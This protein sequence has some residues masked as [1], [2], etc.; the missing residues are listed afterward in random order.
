MDWRNRRA[1]SALFARHPKI[2][3]SKD[4]SVCADFIFK[5]RKRRLRSRGR[6]RRLCGLASSEEFFL[7]AYNRLG[8]AI[9]RPFGV[10]RIPLAV[11]FFPPAVLR[12]ENSR[13][14]SEK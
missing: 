1:G 11:A 12:A 14:H 5:N 2:A 8:Q 4:G 3:E 9:R 10:R 6:H 13:R 7:R